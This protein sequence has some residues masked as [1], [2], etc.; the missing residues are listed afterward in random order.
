MVV[1]RNAGKLHHTELHHQVVNELLRFFLRKRSF[2][3]VALNIDVEES[4]NTTYRHRRAVLRFDRCQV[5]E[6][7]PLH[8]FVRIVSR[9]RNVVTIDG[10]H[11]FHL[12]QGLDLHRDLFAQANYFFRHRAVAAIAQIL[13]FLVNQEVYTI[14]RHATIVADDTSTSIRIRKTCK[15]MV[16][17][18]ELHLIRISIEYAVI[19]RLAILRKYFVKLCRRFIA[20]S[21]ASLFRHLNTAI[22]HK[23]ALQRLIRLQTDNLLLLLSS[24]SDIGRAIGRHTGNNF[25]FHIQYAAFRAL[26]LLQFF[27]HTPKFVRCFSWSFEE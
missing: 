23:G 25:R 26:L 1:R 14:Q 3:E 10:R 15:D 20:I 12:F 17:S 16:V 13:C 27:E 22:G 11:L 21:C 6:V 8:S 4:R 2:F 24:L 18:D 19:V 5:A 7:K 9:F